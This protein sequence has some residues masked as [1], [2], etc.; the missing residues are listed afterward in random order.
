[1]K[2]KGFSIGIDLGGTNIKFCVADRD[3]SIRARH[4]IR[5]P[6]IGCP[7]VI[8]AIV[9]NIPVVLHDAGVELLQVES[10][11]LG[12]PGSVDPDRGVIVFA[13][14]IFARNVEIVKAIRRWYDVPVHLA[15]DSHAAAWAEHMVGA[16]IGLTSVVTVT[17]GTGIGCGI[18]IDG[19][20]Y[21]GS[22]NYTVGE[23]GHQI[24]EFD[25]EKCNCGRFGCLEAYAGGLGILR[26]ARERI[27]KLSILLGKNG[28][29]ISV[30]DIFELAMSGN[31]QAHSVVRDVVKYLGIGLANL[32]NLISPELITVS[33]GISDAPPELLFEPLVEFVRQNTYPAISDFVRIRR[34]PLGCDA[35]LIGVAV[36]HK[37]TRVPEMLMRL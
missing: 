31:V 18:V 33:G 8:K 28:K 2:D 23:L 20:I 1:M 36:L 4:R 34:S 9:A 27:D 30:K 5:T 24:V 12:V 3:G 25:G 26:A 22:L 11:G 15:Q 14:N 7:A 29:A 13:P 32:A 37:H 10:I 21:R 16:G 17:L 35:A 19:K 6:T